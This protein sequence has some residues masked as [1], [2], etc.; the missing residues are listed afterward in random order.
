MTEHHEA[1]VQLSGAGNEAP[2]AA[3]EPAAITLG[4]EFINGIGEA[5]DLFMTK[6]DELREKQGI[7]RDHFP[8]VLHQLTTDVASIYVSWLEYKADPEK[9]SAEAMEQLERRADPDGIIK[10]GDNN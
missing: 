1:T 4:P 7:P 3:A 5:M 8:S 6:L 10:L 9:F 2:P